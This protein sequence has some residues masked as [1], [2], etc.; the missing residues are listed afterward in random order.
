MSS[1]FDWDEGKRYRW[2]LT[3]DG[4]GSGKYSVFDGAK[5]LASRTFRGGG[6]SSFLHTGNALRFLVRSGAHTRAGDLISVNITTVGSSAVS[7]T[8]VTGSSGGASQQAAYFAGSSLSTGFSVEGTIELHVK[9][10]RRHREHKL[11]L[12][13]LVNAGNVSCNQSAQAKVELAYIQADQLDTPRTVTDSTQK[14]I[15]QWDNQEPFGANAPNEDPDGDGKRFTLN[16]RFPGQYFDSEAGLHYNYFRDY[17]A[18]TGR[19]VESDPIGLG[20]GFNTY[21]Y[22]YADPVL[23]AD[24]SGLLTRP[25]PGGVRPPDHGAPRGSTCGAPR[26][27]PNGQPRR[28]GHSGLDLLQA[29]G[30]NIVAPIGGAV[31]DSTTSD[32]GIM[33]CQTNGLLCCGNTS[34]PKETCYR[35]VHID[36]VTTTGEVQEGTV[37]GT[38]RQPS[39]RGI[40]P[41]VHVELYETECVNGRPRR[42]RKCPPFQ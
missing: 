4:K 41:H 5:K 15:W 29:V 16:L 27:W 9:R 42:S 11:Q 14:V 2:T 18:S 37:V 20:G 40:D 22:A 12:E 10:H 19:Y 21:L 32:P 31:R 17:D 25:V 28:G 33:I 23:G 13:F 7:Q 1:S 6:A 26:T 39:G 24:A 3:Y 8:L 35:L 38:V 36:P 30:G 34:V